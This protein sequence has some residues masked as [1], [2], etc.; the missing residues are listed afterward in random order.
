MVAGKNKL[1]DRGSDQLKPKLN[2]LLSIFALQSMHRTVVLLEDQW[3]ATLSAGT[4]QSE[5]AVFAS[6]IVETHVPG[7]KIGITVPIFTTGL[8]ASEWRENT[9][10][11]G[12][13]E[14]WDMPIELTPEK[15]LTSL[16][17]PDAG[18]AP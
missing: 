16:V 9:L 4:Y 17:L 15:K 6:A 2:P 3:R 7:H 10:K 12:Q 11:V 8:P 18:L 14:V 1:I 5:L 13:Y